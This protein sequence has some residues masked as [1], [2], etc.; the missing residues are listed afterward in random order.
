VLA[1]LAVLAATGG[2]IAI[3]S[4]RRRADHVSTP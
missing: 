1:L 3:R 4:H 2:A